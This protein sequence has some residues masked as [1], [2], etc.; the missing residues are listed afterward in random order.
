MSEV[1]NGSFKGQTAFESLRRKPPKLKRYSIRQNGG[2]QYMKMPI[3]QN[4]EKPNL[5]GQGVRQ[6]GRHQKSKMLP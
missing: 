1:K 5:E 6:N 2:N 4:G 3:P